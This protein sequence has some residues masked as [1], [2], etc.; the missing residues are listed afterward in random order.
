MLPRRGLLT[1]SLGIL[2]VSLADA[3]EAETHRTLSDAA[4]TQSRIADTLQNAYG[5]EPDALFRQRAVGFP[6]GTRRPS[7]WVSTGGA[8]ED[9]PPWRVVNHFYDPINKKGLDW[10]GGAP[11]PDWALEPTGP[12]DGQSH[13][14]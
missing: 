13:S 8:Y 5:I 9:L 7:E 11:S 12:L 6:G 14:Y 4:F 1:L 3:Y 10:A 2:T